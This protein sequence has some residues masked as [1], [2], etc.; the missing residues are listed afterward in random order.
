MSKRTNIWRTADWIET[1]RGTGDEVEERSMM[2]DIKNR[3][4]RLAAGLTMCV[5]MVAGLFL[6]TPAQAQY[7]QAAN[8]AEV[9]NPEIFRRDLQV[10]QEGLD[11]DEAQSAILESIYF[12]YEDAFE[13]G[14]Q[15]MLNRF[16]EMRE[17]LQT[18]DKERVLQLVFT[19]FEDWARER[20]GLREDF[21]ANVQVILNEEQMAAWPAFY[22]QF[23]RT[24][25]LPR[26]QFSGERVNLFRVVENMSLPAETRQALEPALESYGVELHQALEQRETAIRQGQA[27]TIEAMRNQDEEMSAEASLKEIAGRVR[28]RNVNDRFIDQIAN[29]LPERYRADFRQGA[30][31]EGYPRAYRPTAAVQVFEAALELDG[32]SPATVNAI[33]QLQSQFLAEMETINKRL[34]SKIRDFEPKQAEHRATAYR[35][36][37]GGRQIERLQDP[38]REDYDLRRDLG[39]RYVEQLRELMTEEQ[40]ARIPGTARV[41]RQPAVNPQNLKET[42]ETR[43]ERSGRVR[44]K[45]DK[46]RATSGNTGLGAGG[47]NRESK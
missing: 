15:A 41:L 14:K 23:T 43:G 26:G 24:K 12:Q 42:L 33:R 46:I 11:L 13:S 44:S 6:A 31:E 19:P 36:Q 3:G 5:A 22:R 21:I 16:Q 30:L 47:G 1:G 34:L 9:L 37:M 27:M 28:V 8:F 17:D 20:L 32:L 40:F 29:Q 2:L 7:G 18:G 39:R 38:T 10:I 45:A 25:A 35:E 4:R